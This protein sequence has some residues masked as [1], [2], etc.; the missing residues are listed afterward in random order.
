MKLTSPLI[1][2]LL[3][4]PLTSASIAAESESNI[5][6][7]NQEY[8]ANLTTA[9]NEEVKIDFKRISKECF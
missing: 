8:R 2:A 1:K 3:L 5:S 7:L 9:Q 6:I 4:T